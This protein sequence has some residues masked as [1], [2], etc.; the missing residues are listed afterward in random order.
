MTDAPKIK[1]CGLT[2]ASDA[3]LAVQAGAWA[4]GLIFW[5]QSP[6]RCGSD[7]AAEIAATLRRQVEIV[8]VFVNPT[9]DEVARTADAVG[10]TMLQLHGEE[11][12]AFCAEAGRRT[13]CKVI[14]AVRVRSGADIQSLSSFHTDYHLL[15]SYTRGVPGGT[16]ATFAWEIAR[17]HR[18]A[19]PMILSGGL[20]PANVAEAISVVR[21]FAV[22][23]ASGVELKP[24][25]KDPD[26]LRAFAAAVASN[27]APQL[28]AL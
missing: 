17:G 20:N 14:K 28:S 27:A 23:V 15:D 12:P 5:P 25:R 6:R 24:G 2:S 10:L 9:L 1:F 13:G 3:H 16:G 26:K 19:V 4:I 8:G 21:P 11:G 7:D 18:G 22:D